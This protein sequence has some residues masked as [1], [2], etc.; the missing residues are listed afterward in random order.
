LKY[1]VDA[2]GGVDR[3]N[4][5]AGITYLLDSKDRVGINLNLGQASGD[6]VNYTSED[7]T[8]SMSYTWAE[9]IGPVSLS[10]GGG[11]TLRKFSEFVVFDPTILGFTALEGGRKDRTA[12]AN[13]N[14]GFPQVSYAGFSP[15]LRLDASR[16]RSNVSRYDRTTFSAGLTISSSF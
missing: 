4:L 13:M 14:I 16:T 5:S 7:Q 15:G 3:T 6:N 8:L 2:I 11:I 12:F 9:P 10:A 1:S